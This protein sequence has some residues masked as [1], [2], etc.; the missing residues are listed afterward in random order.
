MRQKLSDVEI[1]RELGGL[2]GWSRRGE[3]VVKTF[4]FDRFADGIAFVDR[5]AATADAMDHHPDIDIR[6]TKVTL[7]LSTHDAGGV[8]KSDLE[9]AKRIEESARG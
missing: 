5:V 6:Y 3:S 1:Q 9:L 4:A 8:T 2:S 7:S